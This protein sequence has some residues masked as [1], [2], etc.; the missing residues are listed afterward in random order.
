MFSTFTLWEVDSDFD[1]TVEAATCCSPKMK[2]CGAVNMHTSVTGQNTLRTMKL[3]SIHKLLEAN[4][5][6]I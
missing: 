3:W 2:K 6:K 5:D 1:K 4:I